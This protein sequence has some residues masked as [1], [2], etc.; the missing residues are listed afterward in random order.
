LKYIK[1]VSYT[2]LEVRNT[3]I[4]PINE[5][6]HKDHCRL[7]LEIRYAPSQSTRLSYTAGDAANVGGNGAAEQLIDALK[8]AFSR[9]ARKNVL[10]HYI[11]IRMA[12]IVSHGTFE[13]I[14]FRKLP[15]ISWSTAVALV[16]T[17]LT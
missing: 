13:L 16:I 8:I 14:E 17:T 5:A 11:A 7:A 9:L 1:R 15:A 2:A 3:P 10:T 12:I 4:G 6:Q